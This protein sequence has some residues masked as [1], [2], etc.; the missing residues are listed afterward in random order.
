M[1]VMKTRNGK[2]STMNSKINRIL[3]TEGKSTIFLFL[4]TIAENMLLAFPSEGLKK[5]SIYT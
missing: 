2:A 1:F 5:F 4:L 3:S